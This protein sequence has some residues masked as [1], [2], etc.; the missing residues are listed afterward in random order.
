MNSAALSAFGF[1]TWHPLNLSA[2]KTLLAS[3]PSRTGVYAI[4]CCDSFE[5]PLPPASTLPALHAAGRVLQRFLRS[6][7]MKLGE[8]HDHPRFPT[9]LRDL[10]TDALES[11]WTFSNTYRSICHDCSRL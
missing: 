3:L 2:K 4:R 10:V 7:D 5:C 8:I 6:L 11:L 1:I 9:F